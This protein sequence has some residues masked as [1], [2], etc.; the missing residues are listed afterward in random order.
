MKFNIVFSNAVIFILVAPLVL[1]TD[2]FVLG[3]AQ[4]GP[5][6]RGKARMSIH[7]GGGRNTNINVNVN[8]N[9][10][11]G[12]HHHH[13]HRDGIGGFAAGVITGLAIVTASSMP[14]GCTDVVIGGV[15][16]RQCGSTW[17]QPYYQ[18]TT[19]QYIVVNPPI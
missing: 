6:M 13:H 8:V 14:S 16:Y 19:V 18:G 17:F 11:G 3:S 5:P 10:H 15:A 9:K 1:G 7:G 12:G 2:F 4:A